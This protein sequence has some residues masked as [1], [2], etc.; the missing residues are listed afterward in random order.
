[1]PL[2]AWGDN[3][4]PEL[5]GTWLSVLP[6]VVAILVALVFKRVIPALFTGV[7]LGAWLIEGLTVKGFWIGLLSSFEIYVVNALANRDHTAIILFSLMIGGMVGIISRNGGMQ[8]IVN[9]IIRWADSVRHASLCLLYTSP[10][11]RDS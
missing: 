8:G 11:P 2:I 3:T 9:A 5:A 7:F 1:M 4:G 10:S 6:P